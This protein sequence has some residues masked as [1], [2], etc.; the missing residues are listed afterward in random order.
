MN[1]IIL[2][3][4]YK[5]Y[6]GNFYKI[7]AIAKHSETNESLVIYE[8]LYDEHK[9]WARPIEMWNDIIELNGEKFKRFE[10]VKG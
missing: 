1:D 4:T 2:G 6:K 8:A 3:A 7:I 9:I 10:L 5:H